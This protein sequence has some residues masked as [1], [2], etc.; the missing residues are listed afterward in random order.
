MLIGSIRRCTCASL[1][2]SCTRTGSIVSLAFDMPTTHAVRMTLAPSWKSSMPHAF[3][4]SSLS[5]SG[6]FKLPRTVLQHP[7]LAQKASAS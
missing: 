6:H 2:P 3:T 7:Q 5:T 1:H 4:I